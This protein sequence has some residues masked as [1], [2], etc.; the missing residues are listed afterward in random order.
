MAAVVGEAAAGSNWVG[1]ALG[2]VSSSGD[3]VS[4]SVPDLFSARWRSQA[5]LNGGASGELCAGKS[6][7]G[8]S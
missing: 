3:V 8:F 5:W 7:V 4:Y 6:F 1:V 2:G